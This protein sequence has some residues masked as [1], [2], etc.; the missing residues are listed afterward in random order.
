MGGRSIDTDA[1]PVRHSDGTERV[2]RKT[3]NASCPVGLC[4]LRSLVAQRWKATHSS[5]SAGQELRL[6]P[7]QPRIE[8]KSDLRFPFREIYYK[9]I[10][11]VCDG[12]HNYPRHLCGKSVFLDD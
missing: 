7:A 9:P 8:R 10:S 6:T 5:S 2:P 12:Y 3:V 11:A 1:T 4:A